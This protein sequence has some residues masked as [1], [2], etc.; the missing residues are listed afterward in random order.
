MTQ[1][2]SAATAKS[3]E[4]NRPVTDPDGVWKHAQNRNTAHSNHDAARV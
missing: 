4:V 3:R 1:W 2:T